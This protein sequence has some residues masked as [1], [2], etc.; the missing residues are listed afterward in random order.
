MGCCCVAPAWMLPSVATSTSGC[1]SA[2]ALVRAWPP[3]W[4]VVLC[5]ATVL[6]DPPLHLA[7]QGKLGLQWLRR[8]LLL[9]VR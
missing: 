2:S 6:V 7:P 5:S 8:G 9:V 1:P 3:A 4:V